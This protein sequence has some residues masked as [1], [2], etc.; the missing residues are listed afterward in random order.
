MDS[1]SNGIIIDVDIAVFVIVMV[2]LLTKSIWS[3]PQ[4]EWIEWY[5]RTI[6]SNKRK[7][8]TAKK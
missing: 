7:W 6:S 8:K 2:L 3:E 5:K 1:T 4:F